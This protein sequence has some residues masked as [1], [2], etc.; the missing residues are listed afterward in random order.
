M[1]PYESSYL[2]GSIENISG[3]NQQEEPKSLNQPSPTNESTPKLLGSV[4]NKSVLTKMEK[5]ANQEINTGNLDEALPSFERCIV[6]LLSI[7]GSVHNIE[8]IEYFK[9]LIKCLADH[10]MKWLNED[11]VHM[12]LRILYKCRELISSGRYGNFPE[13]IAQIFNHI[14]CCYRRVGKLERALIYLQKALDLNSAYEKMESTG[15]THINIC[16]I[17]SQIGKYDFLIL[18]IDKFF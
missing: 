3:Y 6:Q 5:L 13:Q 17:M 7:T 14:A 10:A 18:T 2:E 1:N 8:F 15:I 16:A 9:T 12:S 11:K 4:F